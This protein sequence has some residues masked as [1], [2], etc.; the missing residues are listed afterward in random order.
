V[1]MVDAA[2]AVIVESANEGVDLVRASVSYVLDANIENLTL[3]GVNAINGGGNDADNVLTGNTA[4][5]ALTG[6]AGNDT[7]FGDA[8]ADALD[9]GAG[10][11][12]LYGGE[13]N[14]TLTGGAGDVLYGGNGNDV[15]V[16]TE[17]GAS[18]NSSTAYNDA[19]V[20][21]VQAAFSYSLSNTL[22]TYY[23][24]NLTLTGNGDLSA[25]GNDFDNVITG[26]S[27]ANSLS[28]MNGNDVL[29]GGAGNDFLNGGVGADTMNGG[30]GN[31]T[32]IVDNA[33]D[34]ATENLNE[35]VDLVM[36]SIAYTL[37]ANVENLTLTGASA[38]N[39]TGNSLNN[40]LTGNSAANTLNGGAGDDTLAGGGGA[41]ALIGGLGND[42][43][44]VYNSG[45]SITENANEGIDTVQASIT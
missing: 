4:D 25:T 15:Y 31:D 43:Y 13:G 11:D 5:N 28:G 39:G 22:G 23:V 41:D 45:V 7:L 18:V 2:G 19:G 8:G 27:G 24:E 38:I 1:Y 21:T 14:D 3:T 44:Q 26:N 12:T 17:S 16:L 6:G 34:V 29:N 40:V 35:G 32:F 10:A 30:L 20:D 36:S 42:L 37:G 9:G 33:A